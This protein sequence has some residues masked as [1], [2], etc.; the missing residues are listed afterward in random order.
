MADFKEQLA[1]IRSLIP[2]E[3]AAEFNPTEKKRP[4]RSTVTLKFG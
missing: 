4:N 2:K 1:A 3:D